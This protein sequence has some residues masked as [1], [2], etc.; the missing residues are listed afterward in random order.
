MVLVGDL[1][2]DQHFDSQVPGCGYRDNNM[3]RPH[4]SRDRL[5]N[6]AYGNFLFDQQ[7]FHLVVTGS[8]DVCFCKSL[9]TRLH[10][11]DDGSS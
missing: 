5:H 6:E 9:Q 7:Y 3:I 11:A 10:L 8:V 2:G 1:Y 4:T